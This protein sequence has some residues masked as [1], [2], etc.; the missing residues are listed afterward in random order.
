MITRN[1]IV[2]ALL[3]FAGL[4][5]GQANEGGR[6]SIAPGE[7]KDSSKPSDGAITGG[8]ILPGEKGGQPEATSPEE[9]IRRCNELSGTLRDQCLLKERDSSIG[10]SKPTD[11]GGA[12]TTP[13]ADAPPP[14]NPR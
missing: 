9:R 11:A 4:A 12:K 5:L 13:P 1:L 14:Q 3:A 7:A 6:G 10:G 8:S 2:L